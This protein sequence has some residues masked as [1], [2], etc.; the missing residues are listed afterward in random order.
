VPEGNDALDRR[1]ARPE[2]GGASDQLLLQLPLA[3]VEQ[4]QR[5]AGPVA[6]AAVERALADARLLGDAIHRDRRGSLLVEEPAGRGEDQLA[7]AGGVAA[8]AGLAR[9]GQ[10]HGL[11]VTQ[12]DLGPITGL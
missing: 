7:V 9:D 4:R 10:F 6:E 11:T 5:K 2:W 12:A 8:F 3:R 1:R